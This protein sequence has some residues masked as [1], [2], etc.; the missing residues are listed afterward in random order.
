[1]SQGQLYLRVAIG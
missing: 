1:L